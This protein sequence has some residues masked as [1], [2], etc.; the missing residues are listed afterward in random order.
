MTSPIAEMP[1]TLVSK[2]LVDLDVAALELQPG[3]LGAEARRDRT[4]AGRDE[5]VLGAELLRLAVGAVCASM[6][7]PSPV[8]RGARHLGAGHAP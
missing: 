6:S 1:G 7:T 8:D 5:Q 4:A 2:Q 3:F